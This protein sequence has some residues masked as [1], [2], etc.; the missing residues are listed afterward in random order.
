MNKFRGS[1]FEII[2]ILWDG[3]EL[4]KIEDDVSPSYAEQKA[5]RSNY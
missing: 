4:T 5:V 1:G 2:G 3:E